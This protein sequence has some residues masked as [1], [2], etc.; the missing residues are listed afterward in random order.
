MELS[1]LPRFGPPDQ[2][3][4]ISGYHLT[5]S[6]AP[7]QLR[8]AE[9][10]DSDFLFLLYGNTRAAEVGAWG[11]DENAGREFLQMQYR[12]RSAAY[13]TS[14]PDANDFIIVAD[15]AQVGRLLI[16]YSKDQLRLVDI[17]VL[18]SY[19]KQGI[20]SA[21]LDALKQEASAWNLPLSLNVQFD[22]PAVRLYLRHGFQYHQS[23]SDVY[24]SMV[25]VESH[26]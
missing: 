24:L 25:W 11:W 13:V 18:S 16:H 8:K 15:G 7:V 19:R 12:A 3:P 21:V 23:A 14:F 1:E 17:A 9:A 26:E 2:A 6:S 22:N 10:F 5:A 20:G 4:G